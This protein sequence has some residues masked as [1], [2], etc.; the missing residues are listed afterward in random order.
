MATRS[1]LCTH[2]CTYNANLIGF[3]AYHAYRKHVR[4]RLWWA[5]FAHLLVPQTLERGEC[6]IIFKYDVCKLKQGRAMKIAS[7][8]QFTI[9]VAM[10]AHAL[11]FNACMYNSTITL[12]TCMRVFIWKRMRAT[13]P[14]WSTLVTSWP[15]I[16][17]S[18]V[19]C[20]LE[21]FIP[22]L[23]V[24]PKCVLVEFRVVLHAIDVALC[25]QLSYIV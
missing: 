7:L 23:K 10:L 24:L 6:L 11:G 17:H 20:Y 4:K 16:L 15:I 12:P 22:N 1:I 3:H 25:V 9:C 21:V 13:N 19:G 8:F 18:S 5:T 14:L 2:V